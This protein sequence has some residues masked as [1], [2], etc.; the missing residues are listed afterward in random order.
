MKGHA[1]ITSDA[2]GRAHRILVSEALSPS[3]PASS[4]GALVE[5]KMGKAPLRALLDSDGGEHS[6]GLF[7]EAACA[8]LTSHLRASIDDAH[9]AAGSHTGVS[10]R[11]EKGTYITLFGHG[12]YLQSVGYAV[13][14]AAGMRPVELDALLDIELGDAE[15]VLVPLYG[16]GK[17]AIHLKRPK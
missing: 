15:G 11:R 12:P 17:P 5:Q 6:F 2:H 10:P 16:L 13:A 3:S 7:A 9:R 1:L 14:I 4:C 8:E